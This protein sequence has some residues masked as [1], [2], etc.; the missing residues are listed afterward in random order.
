MT[1]SDAPPQLQAASVAFWQRLTASPP[2]SRSHWLTRFVFLRLLGLVYFFAFLSL[3]QQVL[4]LI[5]RHGLTPA[6][7]FLDRMSAPDGSAFDA[8]LRLPTLFW[9]DASDATLVALAWVGTALSV[10]VVAGYANAL[11]LL[12]LWGL[13]LSFVQIGQIWY[14]F[15]W[16][17]QL[18]ETGFLAV[19][20]CPL[21]DPR[22]FPR[23]PP[24]APVIGLLRW[25][26]FRI[27]LGAGLIKIRGDEC[28][29][30]L[31]CLCYHYE[32][33]PIPNP[34]S[35]VLHAMPKWFHQAGCLANHFVE[36]V[37]PFFVVAPA[38][39]RRCAGALFVLFQVFLIFS[40]NLSF[41]NWLT[42]CPALACLDDGFLRR[43]LPR[44]I[45]AAAERA[46]ANAVPSRAQSIASWTLVA[47][48]AVLSVNPVLNLLSPR[49]WMNTS[50]DR[51]HLVNTYG[52]FGSVGRDRYE[53]VLEG[54]ADEEIRPDSRW[55]AYEFKA[56]PGDPNRRPP[57][58]APYHYR[59]D[60]EIWF[61]A[62]QGPEHHPWVA[63]L[64]WKL[65][66]N[67][68]G[69]LGLLANRPFPDRP[70]RYIRASL[71]RYQFTPLWGDSDAYW[72]RRWVG[73][74]LPPM[75]KDDFELR[76]IMSDQ[77]W[78]DEVK[79]DASPGPK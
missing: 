19:F 1:E 21:L 48:V 57:I 63:H 32:T 29:R 76:L 8:F 3:A 15:G 59:I 13:Y 43:F 40:G 58:I 20:L 68:P 27:M 70:P 56:K 24:P 47:V 9:I 22:P 37:V 38:L 42:I 67:D 75:A 53:V 30:D 79:E 71:Y 39:L 51:L 46:A 10:V 36:L 23:R 69:A 78:F 28:W 64:I 5:G 12:A 2:A 44:R 16:E 61:A 25:L 73:P 55:T 31:S 26:V 34:L 60:W 52:A 77:G 50:F 66:H 54:T 7:L 33:Q 62:M 74:W 72:T 65:L 6:H 45:V 11:L 4:P 35:R 18:L 41:L 49:Q 14:G 17:I